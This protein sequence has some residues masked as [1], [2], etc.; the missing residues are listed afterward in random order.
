MNM[1]HLNPYLEGMDARKPEL[2]GDHLSEDCV[3]NSPFV[4]TPFVGKK[5]V[6][7]VLGVLLG[8]VDEF[9]TTAVITGEKRAAVLLRIRLGEAEVTGIDDVKIGD[10]GRITSMTVH[11]RPLEQIV[12]IQQ[13]LAPLVGVPAMQLVALIP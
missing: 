8:A 11:W 2:L 13:K 7:D 3:L 6:M 12:A 4:G 10:D 9:E 1:D 5:A